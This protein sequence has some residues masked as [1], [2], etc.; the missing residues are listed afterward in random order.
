M[1]WINILTLKRYIDKG[2]G[3]EF[4]IRFNSLHAQSTDFF[5]QPKV[6]TQNDVKDKLY[7][8][9]VQ[10]TQFSLYWNTSTFVCYS[11]LQIY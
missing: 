2:M 7:Y 10:L 8:K 5:W 11:Y 6:I 9:L 3:C 1:I 4:G